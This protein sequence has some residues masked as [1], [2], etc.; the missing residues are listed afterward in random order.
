ME[1]G[2]AAVMP[3]PDNFR[4]VYFSPRAVPDAGGGAVAR[5]PSETV[6]TLPLPSGVDGVPEGVEACEGFG[7]EACCVAGA[8]AGTFF[9][10][11]LAGGLAVGAALAAGALPA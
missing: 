4:T 3:S 6:I 7:F 9:A 1:P 10:T 8:V 11:T 2:A 5:E